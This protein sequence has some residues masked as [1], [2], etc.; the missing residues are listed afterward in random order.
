MSVSIGNFQVWVTIEGEATAWVPSQDDKRFSVNWS[1]S[2]RDRP[3]YA[4]LFIDGV[5]CSVHFMLDMYS[6]PADPSSIGVSYATTS[7]FTRRDFV[8]S[9]IQVTD[10]DAYL[11]TLDAPPAFGTIRLEL[12]EAAITGIQRAPYQHTYGNKVLEA[13]VIHEQSKKAGAHHVR[14]GGEYVVPQPT[15]NVVTGT[16]TGHAPLATFTLNYRP[17]PMLMAAG[18]MPP[19]RKHASSSAS[20]SSSSSSS[21]VGIGAGALQSSSRA[22]ASASSS[23]YTR[24]KAEAMD[25][26]VI[27]VDG[28]V[29]ERIEALEAQLASLRAKK[30]AACTGAVVEVKGDPADDPEPEWR[31]DPRTGK[32]L[33]VFDFTDL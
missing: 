5:S 22:N 12:W 29:D 31:M 6:Y 33:Q 7:D 19:Q 14:F 2:F 23:T 8:F 30:S 18:I 16:K 26:D 11:H 21:R 9:R 20:A 27:D 24:V 10:D 3:V 4:Q 17:A 1:N 32:I 15:V 25:V 13:Q 28:D